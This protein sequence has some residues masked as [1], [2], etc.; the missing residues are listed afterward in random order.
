MSSSNTSEKKIE[1]LNKIKK[2]KKDERIVKL[3][4]KLNE[5]EKLYRIDSMTRLINISFYEFINENLDC[6]SL[7]REVIEIFRRNIKYISKAKFSLIENYF[8]DVR[9]AY[10]KFLNSE[11][12]KKLYL[13][14]K[15]RND[16]EYLKIFTRHSDFF[17]RILTEKNDKIIKILKGE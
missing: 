2:E 11:K 17:F 4:Y 7:E 8:D 3:V 12:Y 1:S 13:S 15:N 10:E 14:I 16:E 9:I 6:L 5:K